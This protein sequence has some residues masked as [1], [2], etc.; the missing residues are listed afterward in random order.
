[1]TDLIAALPQYGALGVLCG[2][3]M[4]RERIRDGREQKRDDKI[5]A[6]LKDMTESNKDLAV[7][8]TILA[9]RVK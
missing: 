7:S 5:E 1:M 6:I 3:L 8:M 2:Y 4:I 9:E